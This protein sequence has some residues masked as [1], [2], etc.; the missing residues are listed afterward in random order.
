MNSRI[1]TCVATSLALFASTAGAQTLPICPTSPIIRLLRFPYFLAGGGGP[2][3]GA[4]IELLIQQNITPFEVWQ[5]KFEN[6]AM[7]GNV[8]S[9]VARGI[10]I[11]QFLPIP[12]PVQ[13]GYFGP[14]SAG[15]YTIVVQP[16]ATNVTPNVNCAILQI[17]LTVLQG[18]GDVPVPGLTEKLAALLAG[19]LALLATFKLRRSRVGR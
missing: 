16:I 19:L 7:A 12:V 18:A 10:Q 9:G 4:E 1:L 17:P 11:P 3:T 2:I 13:A 8:I 14:L 6:I 15:D 5:F